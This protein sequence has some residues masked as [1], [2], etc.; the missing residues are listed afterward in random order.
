MN[1]RIALLS[2]VAATSLILA[3]ADAF[4][5]MDA[6]QPGLSSVAAGGGPGP[7]LVRAETSLVGMNDN[8]LNLP[9]PE[10]G[11]TVGRD[12]VPRLS[13]E[14]TG[15][16]REVDNDQRRSWSAMAA[17]RFVVAANA[18]GRHA[19]T[20]AGGPFVE[21]HNAVHGTLPFAHTE[22]AYVCRA[23][24]GLTVLTGGGVNIALA[25]SPYVTPPPTTCP[26]AG[27]SFSFC[28]DLGPD[29]QEIRAGDTSVHLRL[30][31][32]WQF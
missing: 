12:L 28:F 14:V 11:L 24:F 5:A 16:A 31:V 6:E 7:W 21:I 13:V 15:S 22:L 10:V 20:V 29:A 8:W 26:D 3:T 25:S 1:N 23:P 17:G 32:G 30:A 2:T 27:D 9:L 4:A 19:L 18:T